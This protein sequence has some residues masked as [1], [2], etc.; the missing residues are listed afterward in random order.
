VWLV[1]V[2]N[3]RRRTHSQIGSPLE[4][5]FFWVS[6]VQAISH[7][8]DLL[9]LQIGSSLLE[10]VL[11]ECFVFRAKSISKR[12]KKIALRLSTVVS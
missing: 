11:Q 9:G 1:A 12:A 3:T 10:I 4:I 2:A 8:L 7:S 6:Y 5:C